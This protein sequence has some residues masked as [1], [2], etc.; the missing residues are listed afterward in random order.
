MTLEDF[1]LNAPDREVDAFWAEHGMGKTVQCAGDATVEGTF[2]DYY[3][4]PVIGVWSCRLCGF[5]SIGDTEPVIKPHL[6]HIPHY[7]DRD[8][9]DP[10]CIEDRVR[11]A[12]VMFKYADE[13]VSA[14]AGHNRF[15]AHTWAR[16]INATNRQR[17]L[18]ASRAMG[19]TYEG[20]K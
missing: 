10:K 12:Q 3:D 20:A 2:P 7:T 9:C 11:E 6:S 4:D 16:L 18:A 5:E 13:L 15:H 19:L 1:I 8:R 14:T 17:I